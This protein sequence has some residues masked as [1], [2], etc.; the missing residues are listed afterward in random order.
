MLI[1]AKF[2]MGKFLLDREHLPL[3]PEHEDNEVVMDENDPTS[4]QG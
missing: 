4:V 1:N 3:H 2:G